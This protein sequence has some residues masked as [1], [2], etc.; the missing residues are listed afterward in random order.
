MNRGILFYNST[1]GNTHA[2]CEKIVRGFRK[3]DLVLRDC[4]APGTVDLSAFDFAGFATFTDYFGAHARILFLIDSLP[5]QN[6][7]PAFV[8]NTCGGSSGRTLCD[9]KKR[10]VKKGFRVITG[11]TLGAPENYP[12]YVAK[13]NTRADS[14]D[15][16]NLAAFKSWID[17]ADTLF[18]GECAAIS[19]EKLPVGII[20]KLVPPFP[21]RIS[22]FLMGS[23]RIDETRCTKCGLCARICAWKAIDMNG[24]PSFDEKK[25][26]GCWACYSRCPAR[27]IFTKKYRD[28]GHYPAPLSAYIDKML[29]P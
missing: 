23:K 20:G 18:G 8:F 29:K 1:T 7:K 26:F 21:R 17:H 27:A 6:R 15:A 25:C 4:A 22:R 19:P 2:A 12:P 5:R 14:P 10:L 28:R 13:G 16:E 3:S 11:F 24:Y 9:M